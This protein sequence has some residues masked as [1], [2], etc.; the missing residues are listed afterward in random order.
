MSNCQLQP[1]TFATTNLPFELLGD[2][3]AD[4]DYTS[5]SALELPVG[6]TS[7]AAILRSSTNPSES[8]STV[9][10]LNGRLGSLGSSAD[11]WIEVKSA[12]C[13]SSDALVVNLATIRHG[14]EVLSE[15]RWTMRV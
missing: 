1:S 7:D 5:P 13:R 11:L 3:T 10:P 9:L 15:I 2:S 4:L 8:V 12:S 6:G 14:R